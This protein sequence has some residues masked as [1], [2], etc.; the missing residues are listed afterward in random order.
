[1][2]FCLLHYMQKLQELHAYMEVIFKIHEYI[3]VKATLHA[4]I[5]KLC[6]FHFKSSRS[7]VSIRSS[8]FPQCDAM[9]WNIKFSAFDLWSSSFEVDSSFMWYHRSSAFMWSLAISDYDW[10][11]AEV[12][13]KFTW[14]SSLA[15][16]FHW[17]FRNW[18]M[19]DFRFF[20]YQHFYL[21]VN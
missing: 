20:S 15:L 16:W 3:F 5:P 21:L 7:S 14:K 18:V 11:K 19:Q 10:F 8:S 13:R 12:N 6:T 4:N 1:M 9:R 2:N 17:N